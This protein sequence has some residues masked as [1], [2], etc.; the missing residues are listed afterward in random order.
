MEDSD[1]LPVETLPKARCPDL[2]FP[3]FPNCLPFYPLFLVYLYVPFSHVHPEVLQSLV[4]PMMPKGTQSPRVGLPLKAQWMHMA[5]MKRTDSGWIFLGSTY[6]QC[7]PC[8]RISPFFL[9][10]SY[11][12]TNF[13]GSRGAKRILYS[14]VGLLLEVQEAIWL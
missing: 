12:L 2:F 1:Q 8:L 9:C 5:L 10:A 6:I 14:Q 3:I 7:Y 13:C 4:I 11:G